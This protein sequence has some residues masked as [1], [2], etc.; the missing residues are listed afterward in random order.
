M[1][2]WF[3]KKI[4]RDAASNPA[5]VQVSAAQTELAAVQRSAAKARQAE[6]AR[7]IWGPL[8][9]AAQGDDEALWLVAQDA[10]LFDIKISAVQGLS[11][12]VALKQA[13]R[14]LRNHDRRVHRAAKL[15]LDQLV[16]QRLTRAKAQ[17][18]IEA[19]LKIRGEETTIPVNRLLALD[20][21]WQ[22]LDPL[23]LDPAQQV[24]FKALSDQLNASMRERSETQQ[25][26]QRWRL[27]STRAL[28][29][30]QDSCKKGAN[31]SD[32]TAGIAESKRALLALLGNC[33]EPQA[34]EPDC[35]ALEVALQ[36]TDLFEARL[37]WFKA[38]D[39]S[40]ADLP[41][42]DSLPPIPHPA[43]SRLLEQRFQQ[44]QSERE[45]AQ[46]ETPV[47]RQPESKRPEQ[48][49]SLD[50]LMQQTEAAIAAG[51]LAELQQQLQGIES[52]LKSINEAGEPLRARY[53]SLQAEYQKLKSWQQW[54]SERA[55]EALINEA[56]AMARLTLAAI[57]PSAAHPPAG[58]DLPD[59]AEPGEATPASVEVEVE[60]PNAV[61]LNLQAQRESIN[62]LRR[63][64]KE[65]ALLATA[66]QWQGF[67]SALQL[68]Y[69]PIAEQQAA[70]QARREENLLARL[71]LLNQLDA[72]PAQFPP[73]IDMAADW[74]TVIRG[75]ADF[76][77]AWRQLG[78][79]EHSIPQAARQTLQTR[80]VNSLERLEAPLQAARR[81]AEDRRLQLILRAEGLLAE[82]RQG[83]PMRDAA[84][85][86]RDLQAEWQEQA[87]ALPLARAVENALW[88]RFKQATDAIFAQ[89]EAAFNAREAELSSNLQQRQGLLAQL[90]ELA[91]GN[92]VEGAEQA[93]QKIDFAW[94]QF[95]PLPRNATEGLET[96]FNQARAAAI[97]QL[98]ENAKKPWQAHC[99]GLLARIRLCEERE[100]D[101]ADGTDIEQRWAALPGLPLAWEQA[102]SQRWQQQTPNLTEPTL[103][104]LLLQ[105]EIALDCVCA[106]EHQAARR[107]LKLQQMKATL[108]GRSATEPAN[109]SAWL[110]IALG[111][112]PNSSQRNR[113]LTIIAAVRQAAPG[114]I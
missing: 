82:A 114:R 49:R 70:A 102:I 63:R 40:A 47:A 74:K 99:D 73:A 7:G 103:D 75:L 59:A 10:P 88:T 36:S 79:L 51:H 76:Q 65:S 25:R 11:T 34:A 4:G 84:T 37:A 56:Q 3:F 58:T 29:D 112:Q 107:E 106:P 15:R 95:A 104:L 111:Q 77:L 27:D 113:L 21:D 78:P 39:L 108:E 71:N 6:D 55:I 16:T 54:S 52:L 89:R 72:M 42:W 20:R 46:T 68:A 17:L 2:S 45:P 100:S 48:L 83:A 26:L 22:A 57:P 86:T 8:L 43:L 105:L 30:W 31:S 94:R 66:E 13:E 1:L 109:P 69:A 81:S 35:R 96:K 92:I 85:R 61:K 60:V 23:A 18:L 93:L 97:K 5:P 98:A 62:Q 38:T 50:L 101:T 110:A 28:K 14:A 12:E 19:A 32:E 9:A 90:F 80:L 87:R 33:P 91:E 53:L 41:S 64:W 67:N 44:W 24:Q